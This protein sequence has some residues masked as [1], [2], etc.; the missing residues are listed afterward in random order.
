[1]VFPPACL[2]DRPSA[3]R[4]STGPGQSRSLLYSPPEYSNSHALSSSAPPPGN[5]AP[6]GGQTYSPDHTSLIEFFLPI[7]GQAVFRFRTALIGQPYPQRIASGIP[8]LFFSQQIV[9]G[10]IRVP[11]R[12][13]SPIP[14]TLPPVSPDHTDTVQLLNPLRRQIPVLL[15]HPNSALGCHPGSQRIALPCFKQPFRNI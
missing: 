13:L 2:C 12:S 6:T 14:G 3:G 8:I 5:S 11:S 7:C 4:Q 10:Q 1:M 9:V 15:S